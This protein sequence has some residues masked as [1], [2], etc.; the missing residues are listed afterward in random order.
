MA[1]LAEWRRLTAQL[2]LLMGTLVFYWDPVFLQYLFSH[3][4]DR[5]RLQRVYCQSQPL[6]LRTDGQTDTLKHFGAQSYFLKEPR[7]RV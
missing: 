3:N 1:L 4:R 7:G 6:V 5:K 2:A